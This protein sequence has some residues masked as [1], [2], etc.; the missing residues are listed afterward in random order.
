MPISNTEIWTQALKWALGAYGQV[1]SGSLV[2]L[3]NRIKCSFFHS[4]ASVSQKVLPWYR[5]FR[6]CGLNLMQNMPRTCTSTGMLP[7]GSLKQTKRCAISGFLPY[8]LAP[9]AAAARSPFPLLAAHNT[10]QLGQCL[11]FIGWNDSGVPGFPVRIEPA[12]VDSI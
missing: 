5:N 12:G 4:E 1:R 7:R 3:A 6:L 9:I 11:D 10:H 8:F 2:R